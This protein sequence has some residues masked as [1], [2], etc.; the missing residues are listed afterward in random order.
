MY[1]KTVE[2]YG[3]QKLPED[4][5]IQDWGITY[6]ELEPY[7]ARSEREVGISGKAGNLNGKK[8]EGGNI[9]EG[10]RS[11]EYPM[12]PTK[13]P[14]FPSLFGET[15]KS[16]GYHPYVNATA[17]PSEEYTNPDGVTRPPC[18][19]CGFC[20]RTPCMIGAKAQP[21]SVLL[22]VVQKR[23]SVSLRT[24]ISVRRIVHEKGPNGGG[25][26]RGVTYV[27]ES[28]EEVFQ[29]A[30]LVIAATY[31]LGNNHLL[32]LSGI[33]TPY[34]PAT[35]KGTLGKNLTHQFS[36]AS[37]CSWTSRSIGSWARAERASAWLTSTRRFRSQQGGIHSRRRDWRHD[38]RHAADFNVRR[39]PAFG[40]GSAVGLRVEE[41]FD[42]M[43]RPHGQHRVRR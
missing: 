42:G 35:G 9:F 20:E 39:S 28:G 30:D 10:R 11:S 22:P 34:D 18:A 41:S 5:S 32:M 40:E 37:T 16:L 36:S 15:V 12:G 21:T 33:G 4:H 17:I 6:D 13:V 25:R 24:G 26:A 1:S 19:F 8:I 43:V 2:R 23:K 27:D 3:K 7:Y 38:D 29:P 31:T 14:Y